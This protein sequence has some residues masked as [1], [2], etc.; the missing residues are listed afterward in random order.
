MP[1][2]RR[3]VILVIASIFLV[4]A[5]VLA[6]DAGIEFSDTIEQ[7]L[8]ACAACHGKQGEGIRQNEYYPRIAGKPA[9]YLYRQLVNFRDGRRTYP[10]MVYLVR[11]LSDEYLREIATYYSKLQPPFP[12]RSAVVDQR[13]ACPR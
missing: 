1:Q 8:I 5:S 3:L 4:A 7:R 6:A 10:Q 13:R 9:E 11:H 12:R 2:P